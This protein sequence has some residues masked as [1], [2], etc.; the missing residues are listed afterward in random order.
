METEVE[1]KTADGAADGILFQ[2]DNKGHWPG[3][4]H[5]TD[6]GG[7]RQSHRDMAQRL[8]SQGY[9]VLLPNVFYR[10]GKP[11]VFDSPFKMGEEKSMKRLAEL[12]GPLTPEAMAHDASPYVDFLS[13]RESVSRG[14]LGVVGYCFTGAMALRIAATRP[15]R[16]AAAA[17]FHGGSLYTDAP[18]SPHLLLPQVRA[19]LYFGH[20]FE[21]RS[22]PKEAIE[23]LG[24]A[25]GA[26]GG[27]YES[28]TYEGARH[29]WTVPDSNSAVYNQPQAE[30]AFGKLTAL[31]AET[32]K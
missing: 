30:R 19:R 3:V 4:I 2:P 21:D 17:S 1:I 22:M 28:E 23:K 7:I 13:S 31:F 27:E 6:I 5:L 25:L 15:D 14:P 9:A 20:A 11:P 8:S 26:W 24:R 29:G 16:I 12:T 18:A 32:L 10:T